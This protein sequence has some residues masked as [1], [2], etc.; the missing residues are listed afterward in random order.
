[1]K[2][3]VWVCHHVFSYNINVFLMDDK[4]VYVSIHVFKTKMPISISNAWNII[5]KFMNKDPMKFDFNTIAFHYECCKS[6]RKKGREGLEW[7]ATLS[8]RDLPL[9]PDIC[10]VWSTPLP[11]VPW[12][13]SSSLKFSPITNLPVNSPLVSLGSTQE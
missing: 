10:H 9:F 5:L 3:L 12:I 7:E 1:M 4:H 2:N 6:G 11:L 8:Q 13:L